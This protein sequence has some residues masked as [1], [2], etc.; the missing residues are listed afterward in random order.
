[1][2]IIGSITL[3]LIIFAAAFASIWH[4]FFK[5]DMSVFE[6]FYATGLEAFDSENYILAKNL[7]NKIPVKAPQYKESK[8]NL[9]TCLLKM[10]EYS[11]AETELKE[12]TTTYTKD[13][14][15]LLM[16]AQSLAGQGK[17][18]EAEDLF[19]EILTANE[20][21][22]E[23]VMGLGFLKFDE[24][25]FKSAL[26]Y[27]ETAQG[28]NVEM[29][30]ELEFYII[31]CKDELCDYENEEAGLEIIEKYMT[32][33]NSGLLPTEMSIVLAKAYSKLGEIEEAEKHC[34]RAIMLEPRSAENYKLLSVIQLIKK[35]YE[36]AKKTLTQGLK[37]QPNNESMHEILSYAVCYQVENCNTNRCREKYQ[38]LLSKFVESKV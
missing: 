19:N 23:C 8:F 36:T 7:F 9:C 4:W 21:A 37:V 6:K 12:Y 26:K 31:R 15:A 18:E 32:I 2:H 28:L 1:M 35:D 16:L 30:P 13:Y 14:N 27:F 5:N 22:L 11:N 20:K 34:K 24:K 10:Q 3:N 17:N 25:D 29:S 38:K 33:E